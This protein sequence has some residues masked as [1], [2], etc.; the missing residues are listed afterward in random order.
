MNDIQPWNLSE[1]EEVNVQVIKTQNYPPSSSCTILL[2]GDIP[3]NSLV[4]LGSI[5]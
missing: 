3:S 4:S 1:E 2:F 5:R